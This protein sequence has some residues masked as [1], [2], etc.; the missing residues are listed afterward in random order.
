MTPIKKI[1]D[2]FRLLAL[3]TYDL[4]AI[5]VLG[6]LLTIP[7]PH[8]DCYTSRAKVLELIVASS[9]SR[10]MMSERFD[11]SKSLRAIGEGLTIEKSKRV[12]EGLVTEDGIIIL[13]SDDPPAIVLVSPMAVDG[14]LTW[15]CRGVPR[16][17]T[18]ISCKQWD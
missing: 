3:A 2:G 7:F 14:Q 5:V 8:Y 1:A 15:K 18:P 4:I 11:K 17:F 6:A 16:K 9:H 12:K 13:A 10:H